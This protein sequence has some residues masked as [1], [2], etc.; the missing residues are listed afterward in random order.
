MQL[1]DVFSEQ[2]LN[3]KTSSSRVEVD[4]QASGTET[5]LVEAP[6]TATTAS[7][8]D[9]GKISALT[10]VAVTQGAPE[11]L[12]TSATAQSNSLTAEIAP[13]PAKTSIRQTVTASGA[14]N[15]H[16]YV[17]T[18]GGPTR[19]VAANA[20]ATG[21]TQTLSGSPASTTLTQSNSGATH[22]YL[23]ANQCCVAGD[24]TYSASAAA[25]EI[26]LDGSDTGGSTVISQSRDTA[27]TDAT[28]T[29]GQQSGST[30][31]VQSSAD[32]NS[33]TL[34]PSNGPAPTQ[35]NQSNNANATALADFSAGSSDSQ[36]NLSADSYG[37]TATL[38]TYSPASTSDLSQSNSGTVTADVKFT[39]PTGGVGSG[40][41]MA[42]GDS[43]SVQTCLGCNTSL[44]LSMTQS[45]TGAVRAS[46]GAS[47]ALGQTSITAQATGNSLNV[48]TH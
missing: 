16:L 17:G 28:V 35:L 29:G 18:S 20:T 10:S 9:A 23:Q 11:G 27:P 42:T 34:T 43:A 13:S 4:S 25:N 7:Q 45:N 46:S 33:A 47:G 31:E 21:N 36:S 12:S 44:S 32:G 30:V 1:G 48:V 37:N 19:D 40:A 24:A 26:T 22:A 15:A 2:S 38:S 8:T 3:V 39:N 41:S 5:T 6:K 14:A